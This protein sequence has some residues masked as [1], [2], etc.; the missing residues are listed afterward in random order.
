VH[1]AGQVEHVG[2]VGQVPRPIHPIAQVLTMPPPS[3]YNVE[4]YTYP[5]VSAWTWL[6]RSSTLAQC[7]RSPVPSTPLHR[8]STASG[9]PTHD[10]ASL[11]TAD[12]SD[13][14]TCMTS[15]MGLCENA[16]G[17]SIDRWLTHARVGASPSSPTPSP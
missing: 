3:F 16:R 6:A 13:I 4:M 14:R 17:R 1:L 15:N 8:C 9:P 12:A 2:P 7:V 10:P 5:L 11:S